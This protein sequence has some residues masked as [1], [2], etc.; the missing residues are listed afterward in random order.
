MALVEFLL[1]LA[2]AEKLNYLIVRTAV[3][4]HL[5]MQATMRAGRPV[6]RATIETRSDVQMAVMR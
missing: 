2:A 6:E 5:E 3:S 1:H 4:V